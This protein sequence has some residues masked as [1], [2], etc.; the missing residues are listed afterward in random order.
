MNNNIEIPQLALGT[1]KTSNEEII[2]V[3]ENAI[4]VGYRH[5]DCAW[6][7][8]NEKGIGQGLANQLKKGEIKRSDLFL[9]S[10]LWSSFHKFERVKQQCLITINHLQCS[11]LD[12][13][14]IHW[15]FAFIDQVCFIRFF[16][17]IDLNRL[18]S[19]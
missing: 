14:L 3:I 12:L 1:F 15:P 13:F 11:Y 10:K 7:Y 6:I 2:N 16:F 17:S 5:I 4:E 8:G 18:G 9:T 19:I